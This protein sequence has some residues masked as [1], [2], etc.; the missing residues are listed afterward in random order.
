MSGIVLSPFIGLSIDRIG[1]KALM[2]NHYVVLYCS[3]VVTVVYLYL[4]IMPDCDKCASSIV[5]MAVL[6]I[7]YCVYGVVI[8]AA[9]PFVVKPHAVGTAFG[10][11]V[12]TLNIGLS[13]APMFVGWL[14]DMTGNYKMVTVF[15]LI[16]GVLSVGISLWLQINDEKTGRVLN[17]P[18]LA[19]SDILMMDEDLSEKVSK[20]K[21]LSLND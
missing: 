11:L 12:A 7:T 15:F 20:D 5:P 4:L 1:R 19:N 9:I 13:I 6:G 18:V 2:S 10:V 16:C 14:Y 3:I 21:A 17:S 8:W